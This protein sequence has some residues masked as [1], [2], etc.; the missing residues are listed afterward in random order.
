[1]NRILFI[2]LRCIAGLVCLL[3]SLQANADGVTIE[4]ASGRVRDSIYLM[5]AQI[6]YAL[7]N[8]VLEAIAHGIQLHFDVTVEIRRRRKWIWDDVVTSETLGYVLQYQPLSN[9]YLVTDLSSGDVETLQELDE[10]LQFLGTISDHPLTPSTEL[11]PNADY[12]GY[13]MSELK[14]TTLPL[15]LQPLAYISPQW[16]LTSQ[17]YEWTIR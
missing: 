17:W 12:R 2:Q 1:M 5:D 11:E 16:H 8:S 15:P 14:I 10:A 6:D 9:N 3:L 13:I 7:S 4:H